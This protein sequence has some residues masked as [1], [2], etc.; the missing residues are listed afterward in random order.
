MPQIDIPFSAGLDV[1]TSPLL[2]EA[3]SLL[4]AQ[5]VI[6]AEGGVPSKRNGY[7]VLPQLM[8]KVSL[9]IVAASADITG[10]ATITATGVAVAP[11]MP[12]TDLLVGMEADGTGG[13]GGSPVYQDAAATMLCT[14]T[15]QAVKAWRDPVSGELLTSSTSTMTYSTNGLN[16]KPCVLGLGGAAG[17][18][19]SYLNA[20]TGLGNLDAATLF[21]VVLP[22]SAAAIGIIA[23]SSDNGFTDC[24]YTMGQTTSGGDAYTMATINPSGAGSVASGGTPS[25]SAATLLASAWSTTGGDATAPDY[26]Y[27]DGTL[28]GSFPNAHAP[29]GT[30]QPNFSVGGNTY[31]GSGFAGLIAAV[32]L[33][34]GSHIP[35]DPV[36]DAL[37]FYL[38]SKYGTP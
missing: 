36:Y 13:P 18:Y 9:N 30:W 5:N 21:V 15:G 29:N 37:A 35:G 33:L 25:S 11:S 2:A 32:A 3:P 12:T 31:F 38:K 26:L 22:T 24:A 17:S 34:S 6:Y 10:R 7:G 14:T 16:G 1:K 20:M 19:L 8:R 4:I 28:A 23:G 27:Q